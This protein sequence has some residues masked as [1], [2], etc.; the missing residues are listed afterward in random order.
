MIRSQN[1]IASSTKILLFPK[2]VELFFPTFCPS[3]LKAFLP[4]PKM[5]P[6]DHARIICVHQDIT[7][8][9]AVKTE[10]GNRVWKQSLKTERLFQL[11]FQDLLHPFKGTLQIPEQCSLLPPTTK[12]VQ[13]STENGNGKQACLRTT[14]ETSSRSLPR[15]GVD[16]FALL[17]TFRWDASHTRETLHQK[18]KEHFCAR[19][20]NGLRITE[21]IIWFQKQLSS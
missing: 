20:E 6:P 11:S 14:L 5:Y 21:A 17:R 15:Q 13:S 8:P 2:F 9:S 1:E 18:S 19:Y 16:P 10:S 4:L 12:K 7:S 3:E